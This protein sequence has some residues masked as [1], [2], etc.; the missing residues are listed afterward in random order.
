[1]KNLKNLA[2]GGLTALAIGLNSQNMNSRLPDKNAF[3]SQIIGGEKIDTTFNLGQN[4][5]ISLQG[6]TQMYNVYLNKINV[7]QKID[8]ESGKQNQVD[9]FEQNTNLK[10]NAYLSIGKDTVLKLVSD[11]LCK[12]CAIDT[13]TING[14]RITIKNKR[15]EII[16]ENL[17]TL[18]T[19][20]KE[21]K[22]YKIEFGF[23]KEFNKAE[24]V[25]QL[26]NMV[27]TYQEVYERHLNAI[28]GE[29]RAKKLEFDAHKGKWNGLRPIYEKVIAEQYLHLRFHIAPQIDH[30]IMDKNGF[31]VN[32]YG[33]MYMNDTGYQG[34]E[35]GNVWVSGPY[36]KFGELMSYL[37]IG[38]L[39]EAIILVGE[40]YNGYETKYGVPIYHD[41]ENDDPIV[42]KLESVMYFRFSR[43]SQDYDTTKWLM[44]N[45]YP[46]PGI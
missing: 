16:E 26:L 23:E 41:H 32:I 42:N 8:Y 45:A 30:V 6:Y 43:N 4:T 13:L 12:L 11:P 34:E 5:K 33:E 1:M 29:F 22:I 19:V 24:D 15:G 37:V 2:I 46:W 21:G 14:D 44:A 17:Q 31:L 9:L 20:K 38:P 40:E 28:I 39:K 27:L 35:D 25:Y 18:L 10:F 7:K 36:Q 3:Y